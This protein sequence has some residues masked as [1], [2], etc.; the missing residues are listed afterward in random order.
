MFVFQWVVL[1]RF[2]YVSIVVAVSTAPCHVHARVC[3]HVYAGVYLSLNDVIY[4]NNSIIPITEIG[5]TSTTVTSNTGLQCITDRR[6]CCNSCP[7]RY[8]EW[9]FPDGTT[10]P[11][12]SYYYNSLFYRN[13]GD[14]GTVNLNRVN[15]SV[16]MPTG[17]FCCMVHDAADTEQTVC[18]DIGIH[19]ICMYTYRS[20]MILQVFLYIDNLS[21]NVLSAYRK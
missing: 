10:V 6:P 1:H 14:D 19:S 13:R 3:M 17:Q 9:Y 21:Y 12:S 20:G 4:A 16:T 7:N 18:A 8:G 11:S 5:E 2:Q 15:A